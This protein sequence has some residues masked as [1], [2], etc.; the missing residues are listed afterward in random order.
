MGNVEIALYALIGLVIA[1]AGLVAYLVVR[2][3]RAEQEQA[4]RFYALRDL[5]RPAPAEK[6]PQT[7][8]RAVR[9]DGG[10]VIRR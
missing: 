4:A 9:L 7:G 2:V 8:A 6:D 3:E 1:N 10:R 5:L